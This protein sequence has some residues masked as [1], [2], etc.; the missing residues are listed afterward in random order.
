MPWQALELPSLPVALLHARLQQVRPGDTVVEY[1]G[2]LRWAEFLLAASA[3]ELLPPHYDAV[4]DDGIF[5]GLGDWVFSGTLYDDPQWGAGQLAGYAIQ[6]GVDIDAVRR[7]RPYADDFI[8]LAVAEILELAP[9]LVGLTTTFMQNVPSLALARRLKRRAPGLVIVLG[10]GNCDG[11]MGHALHRSHEFVDYV[12]GGEGE[13][14]FPALLDRI[15]AGQPPADVPGV[16]WW[17]GP[18]SVANAEPRHSVPPAVI[19]RP[20]F[21]AWRRALEASRVAEYVEPKLVLEGARGCWWGEKHQC[22]FCGLNGSFINFRSQPAERFWSDLSYLVQRHQILDLVMVDNI[23][24]MAYFSGLLPRLAAADW[25]MRVHY[26][27]KANLRPEQV[28]LLAA[29]GVCHLQP[30]IESLSTRV[31]HLMDKGAT[32][33]INARLLREC[34]NHGLTASWNY[35]YG[36]PGEAAADYTAI[37]DQMPA[38]SHL[39]PP[40]AATRITLER[41]SPYFERPELGFPDRAPAQMYRHVY[42]LPAPELDDLVYLF[43]SPAQG[44]AG[45]VADR[46]RAAV[47]QWQ[48]SYQSS[49]LLASDRADGEL[50]IEDRRDQWPSRTYVLTGWQAAAYRALDRGRDVGS[51]TRSIAQQGFATRLEQ[52]EDWLHEQVA[53]GLAFTDAGSYVAL[54]TRSVPAKIGRHQLAEVIA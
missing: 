38:L 15:E 40:V 18:E 28:E 25:D 16:C 49:S 34:E 32:G 7:M 39:Q 26:E 11:P 52:L 45:E 27:V 48:R 44:I 4:V 43:D 31:L 13:L 2:Q 17:Q 41:F 9:D 51:L 22:T 42:Q 5:H 46:L 33:I 8:D 1:H 12:V 37:I 3:G 23:I 54:A 30:G 50:A 47:E 24:D 21:D 6:H 35:L 53:A 10:G 36:F 20:D 29:A 19:P 14:A